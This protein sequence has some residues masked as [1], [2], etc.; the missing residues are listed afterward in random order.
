MFELGI[1][2]APNASARRWFRCIAGAVSNIGQ[3]PPKI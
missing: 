3:E 2:G 1:G